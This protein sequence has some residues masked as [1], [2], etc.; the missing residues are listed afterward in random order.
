MGAGARERVVR[1]LGHGSRR[2][3]PSR[4]A[5]CRDGGRDPRAARPSVASAARAWPGP[6]SAPDAS[7]TR[8]RAPGDGR[9]ASDQQRG[10]RRSRPWRSA[11][12][13]SAVTVTAGQ[14]REQRRHR[15]QRLPAAARHVVP[16]HRRA[17]R[18]SRR[19]GRGAGR[20]D[21]RPCP[22]PRPGRGRARARRCR[23]SS[24]PRAR[25]AS[26]C[27][28]QH[29]ER[30][31]DH[32]AAPAA[33]PRPRRGGPGR[34]GA[35]RRRAWRSRRA[36]PGAARPPGARAAAA[37]SAAVHRDRPRRGQRA[38]PCRSSVVVAKPRRTVAR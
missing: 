22:A 21:A 27:D 19:C 8:T 25:R 32:D 10:R 20:R 16:A 15:D 35:R 34:R 23:A 4:G 11:R 29:V 26:P 3:R 30:V 17:P 13:P 14:V 38:R 31:D 2:A 18:R 6:R 36:A 28:G 37:T 24:A 12:C 7:S 5:R 33:A 1:V 9:E